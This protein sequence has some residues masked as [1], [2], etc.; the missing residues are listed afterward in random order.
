[1]KA[2]MVN[3]ILILNGLLKLNY[4]GVKYKLSRLHT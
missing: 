1:M 4:I 3:K 2:S